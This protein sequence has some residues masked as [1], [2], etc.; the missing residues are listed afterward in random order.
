MYLCYI[1][2]DLISN[3]EWI[4]F[5]DNEMT[6]LCYIYIIHTILVV[7][8]VDIMYMEKAIFTE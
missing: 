2:V 4:L 5:I 1:V 6:I 3:T 7:L 8:Y